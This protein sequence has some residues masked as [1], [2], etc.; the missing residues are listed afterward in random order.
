MIYSD[1]AFFDVHVNGETVYAVLDLLLVHRFVH[2]MA[3][4]FS[5]IKDARKG[6]L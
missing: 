4:C 2:L 6:T 3:Y 5:F 1:Q